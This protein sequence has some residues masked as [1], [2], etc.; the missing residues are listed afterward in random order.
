M[1]I[2]KDEPGRSLVVAE[3]AP[4]MPL[5]FVVGGLVLVCL[6][7]APWRGVWALLRHASEIPP[8]D[9]IGSGVWLAIGLLLL[10]SLRG[11]SRI[12]R[13]AADRDGGLVVRSTHLAGFLP[14]SRRVPS[15]DLQ[16]LSL[17][18]APDSM[19][20][21]ASGSGHPRPLRL[22]LTLRT[23]EGRQRAIPLA[24]SQV[25]RTSEVA[26]LALRL[27]AAVGLPYYRVVGS[28]AEQF[29]IELLRAAEAGAQAIPSLGGRADYSKDVVAAP[30]TAAA[31]DKARRFDPSAF[32]GTPRVTAWDPRHRV[33]FEKSWGASAFVAPL[34]AAGL[35]GPLAWW[36]LPGLHG[37]PALPRIVALAFIT[38]VGFAVAA[39]GWVGLT[40]ALPRRVTLDWVARSLDVDGLRATRRVPF[41]EVEAIELRARSF[42]ARQRQNQYTMYY[43][44][45]VRAI[46][47][48][49]AGPP[50]EEI[51][52]ETRRYR[53]DR[54]TPHVAAAPLARELAAA[55][56]VEGRKT[57][58]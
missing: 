23:A 9:L 21:A 11:G 30:A 12:E 10:F 58:S 47:R 3:T 7:A 50:M 6:V 57:S 16:G 8:S 14:W 25:G 48:A 24:L 41:S 43:W 37:L 39:I 53:E 20:P 34:L 29:E 44:C 1:E 4:R 18:V 52:A 2:I 56:D 42:R 13:V 28:D 27:G 54:V 36:R 15:N 55:L 33:C 26:D 19:Q 49:S 38:L 45:E 51:L 5:A 22:R 17:D 35:A 31:A 46:L 40:S 32:E